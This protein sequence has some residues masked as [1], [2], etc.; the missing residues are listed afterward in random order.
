MKKKKIPKKNY[1][2]LTLITIF[3]I[4]IVFYLAS[5]YNATKEYYM[6]N[7]IMTDFLSEIKPEEIDN[8]IMD[9]PVSVIY[10]A[11]SKNADIKGFEKS[12][13]KLI[14]EEEIKDSIIYMDVYKIVDNNFFPDL[15]NNYFSDELKADNISLTSNPN[16]IVI[17]NRQIVDILNKNNKKLE[18][19]STKNLLIK[20]GIIN[21]D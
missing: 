10:L 15:K 12:F 13:K 14:K 4:L 3:S 5:W 20:H 2:I 6:N 11:S 17:E 21:N 9:N 7:S 1:I 18:L 19:R 16:I 8:Y